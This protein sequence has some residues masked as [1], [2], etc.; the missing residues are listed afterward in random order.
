VVTSGHF[1]SGDGRTAEVRIV[2][3]SQVRLVEV[4]SVKLRLSGQVRWDQVVKSR[5]LRSG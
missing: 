4:S 3:I 1:S 2:Q 5:Q